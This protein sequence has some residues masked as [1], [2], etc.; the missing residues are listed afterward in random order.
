MEGLYV[1]KKKVT[2]FGEGR[3]LSAE[4]FNFDG[5]RREFCVYMVYGSL[6]V[7]IQLLGSPM[8]NRTKS[9][10]QAS[11]DPEP[12]AIHWTILETLCQ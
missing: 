10:F 9:W 3:C 4:P 7:G 8:L 6:R 1:L 12:L 5:D 11:W 2:A